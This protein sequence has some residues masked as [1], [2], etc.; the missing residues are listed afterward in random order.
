MDELISQ[1][2]ALTARHQ[3]MRTAPG[4]GP[5]I[6][7]LW[8]S[9]FTGEEHLNARKI[10]SRFGFAPHGQRSGSSVHS[11]D[12]STGHGNS[13]MR[14]LMHQA[15]RSVANHKPHSREYYKRKLEEGKHELLVINNIINKLIRLYCAM[16]NNQSEYDPNHI[17]NMKEQW[18]K[19]A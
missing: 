10:S 4:I 18:K 7:R 8:L 2:E 17:Q 19:S 15:A 12:R 11:P 14:K 13:E 16:W 1:D 5:V 6:G 9:L 3:M